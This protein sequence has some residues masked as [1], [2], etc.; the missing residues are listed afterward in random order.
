MICC[1]ALQTDMPF[2]LCRLPLIRVVA[3]QR[4]R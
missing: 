4:W 3:K 2:V 1:A